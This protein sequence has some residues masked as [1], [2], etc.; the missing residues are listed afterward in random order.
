LRANLLRRFPRL[1]IAGVRPSR[2][3]RL[4]AAERDETIAVIRSS[5]AAITF[6]GLGC[7]RQEVW[8]YEFRQ[9][10]SMPVV[11]VGAAFSF[12]AGDLPQAPH[13]LQDRGLEWL[14]RFLQEPARLWKR[15]CLL[16]PLY[17]SLLVVQLMRLHPFDPSTGSRPIDEIL[18][19]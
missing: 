17:L 18:Y 5:A 10:L 13:F 6:V 4:S 2:F 12:H 8:A 14:F 3:R 9:A 11:A 15:Y 7:P 19:G 1:R 16:N